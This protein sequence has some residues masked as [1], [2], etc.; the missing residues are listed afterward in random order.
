MKTNSLLLAA[1]C[2]LWGA[3]C[4]SVR[5]VTLYSTPADAEVYDQYDGTKSGTTPVYVGRI[6]APQSYEV[7]KKG[8]VS[9]TVE[10]DR[11]S[12][13]DVYVTLEL[14]TPK[15]INTTTLLEVVPGDNGLQVKTSLVHSEKDVIE[16]SPNVKAV[17]R[18]TDFPSVRQVGQFRLDPAGKKLVMEILDQENTEEGLQQL[19]NLWLM[20]ALAGGGLQRLTDGKYFDA[21]AS[22]SPDGQ[23][24]YFSANRAG[25]NSIFR[26]AISG[27]KGLSLITSGATVDGLPS[28]SPDGQTLMYTAFM[29]AS[30]I[31]QLWSLPLE[32]GLPMQLREG[33]APQWS[34][35]GKLILY[36]ATDR[37]TGKMKIWTMKPDSTEPTQLT[38]SSGYNDIEPVWTPDGKQI[39]YASDRGVANGKQ[40]YDIWI[41]NADGSNPQQ[42]TTNGSRD[43][44]PIVSQEGKTIYFRSNR[45]LKWDIWVVQLAETSPAN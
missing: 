11:A 14:E 17:R 10:L 2:I 25:R 33:S 45:G 44:K 34:P 35:D 36:S 15:E 38:Q 42:L 8:Y 37:S 6:R 31:P 13:A 40:N 41:M 43:D 19:S 21:G 12:P 18:L 3:G 4:T 32:K 9:K 20:D 27:P 28:V 1:L 5:P 29:D 26:L 7:R 24:V 16:R 23:V 30:S 22:Y 39:V